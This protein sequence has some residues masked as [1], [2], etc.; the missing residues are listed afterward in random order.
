MGALSSLGSPTIVTKTVF[1]N[2]RVVIGTFT[3]GDSSSTFPTAGLSFAPS[4]LGMAKF[5][6]VQ[7]DSDGQQVY[8]YNYST[9]KIQ[10]YVPDG[11]T[12]ADKIMVAAANTVPV[13][14]TIRFMVVGYGAF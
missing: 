7:I 10:A 3:F 6:F 1:G 13:A 8:R 12:G 5:Q 14:G 9:E 11:T 4:Q 2:K